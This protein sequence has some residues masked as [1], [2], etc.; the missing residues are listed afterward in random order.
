MAAYVKRERAIWSKLSHVGI[1]KLHFSFTDET[2]VYFVMDYA[3]NGSLRELLLRQC[4]SLQATVIAFLSYKLV[5]HYLAEL[6]AV[7]EYLHTRRFAHRD[8]KP[9]NILLDANMHI[10]LT[11]FGVAKECDISTVEQSTKRGVVVGTRE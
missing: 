3:P 6:V 5:Q 7:L 10:K 8:L 2:R 9:E 4:I 1:I 11:D